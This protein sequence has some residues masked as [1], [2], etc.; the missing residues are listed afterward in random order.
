MRIRS[1]SLLLCITMVFMLS[2][3][4]SVGNSANNTTANAGTTNQKG[5]NGTFKAPD[6]SG[7]I[8]DITGNEVTLKIIKMP[9]RQQPGSSAR[10]RGTRSPQTSPR[11]QASPGA[12]GSGYR[13]GMGQG[14]ART[15]TYTGE[16]KTIVIPVGTKLTSTSFGQG[17][18]TETEVNI[19]TLAKGTVLSIYYATDKKTIDK[20]T[21][22]IQRTGSGGNGR[23]NPN[24]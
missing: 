11:P 15:R 5:A 9:Q 12:Q 22:Q 14:A 7:E 10:P 3:C 13:G 8:S 18:T 20:I 4:K 19:N 2:A 6:I 1:L 23:N 16:V 21:V 17:G 24:D